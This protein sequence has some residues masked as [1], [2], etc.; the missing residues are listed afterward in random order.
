M[1]FTIAFRDAMQNTLGPLGP[2]DF[3]PVP[4]GDIHRV[5]IPG[6]RIGTRNGWYVLHGGDFA[7][8]CYG[9]WKSAGTWQTWSSR[10]PVDHLEAEL[11]RQRIEQAKRQRE[12]EL[13]QRNQS[14]AEDA[15]QQW[16]GARRAEADHSY[17]VA[18]GIE[19]HNL[20]QAGDVLLVPLYL[21]GELVNLQRIWPDGSKRFLK[22]GMV[23]GCYSP[24]GTVEPGKP[25]YL[26]EGWATGATLHEESDAV[27]ACAMN[28]GNLLEAG[29]RLQCLHPDAVVIIAGD[30]DR[31]TEG[32][33]GRTA[34]N[35]SAAALGCEVIMPPW[36]GAEP[37]SLS[38]FND[39]ARWRAAQ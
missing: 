38:D 15:R 20:R 35:K 12:A 25:V 2:L 1:D 6:D 29:S 31:Q 34:A 14:T 23:K 32:N 4:D 28:C 18:K 17:L 36:S 8:G 11:L 24:I 27:V 7:S 33:P 30:D 19:P 3:L 21:N 22:G 39:L 5:H 10:Q 9:T 13:H 16:A 26:V 37:V